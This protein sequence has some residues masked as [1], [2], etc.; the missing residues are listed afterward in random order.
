MEPLIRP[1]R[2]H[3]LPLKKETLTLSYPQH[4]STNSIKISDL[5]R[6]ITNL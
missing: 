1:L 2:A 6:R 5:T 4:L 3:L